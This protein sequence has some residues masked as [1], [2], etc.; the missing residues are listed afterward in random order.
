MANFYEKVRYI[1]HLKENFDLIW[2]KIDL[3]CQKANR[4]IK[5]IR[6]LPVSKTVDADILRLAIDL[7][8][9]QFGE[10]KIQE[11]LS[12]SKQL[13][14]FNPYWS[15]I[16]HLQTNKIKYMAQFAN[17]FQALDS[18]K[19]A[20]ILNE[21]LAILGR[22][23]DVLVQVNTSG[24]IS[25]FGI[26]P[27]QLESFLIELTDFKQLK[28]KGLMTLAVNSNDEKLVRNCF[29]LLRNL[30]EKTQPNL[31]KNIELSE[32][33][34]GMSG[35]FG[36]AILEGATTIRIGQALFGSRK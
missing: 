26:N 36:W 23:M 25:K 21:K 10:N 3:F 27:N 22:E 31:P 29:V 34:M 32:L 7:G 11:A 28:I 8:Y 4:D 2:Q 20:Q 33:S 19:V 17:E 24:E 9:C 14:D 13:V 12:K 16:G 18:L 1:N 5:S 6:L 35:D 30:K 15:I